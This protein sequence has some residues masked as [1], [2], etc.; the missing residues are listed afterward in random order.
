LDGWRREERGPLPLLHIVE[1]AG[2]LA[3]GAMYRGQRFFDG[4]AGKQ[5]YHLCIDSRVSLR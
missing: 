4:G 2:D 3:K 1:A 5:L